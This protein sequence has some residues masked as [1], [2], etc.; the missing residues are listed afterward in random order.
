MASRD[1]KTSTYPGAEKSPRSS[2]GELSGH[3]RE[4][5]HRS[6]DKDRRDGGKRVHDRSDSSGTGLHGTRDSP[7]SSRSSGSSRTPSG[8]KHM[9][10]YFIHE[11]RELRRQI[12]PDAK[13]VRRSRAGIEEEV[14]GYQQPVGEGRSL[15][16][17]DSDGGTSQTSR[18]QMLT[19]ETK[20]VIRKAPGGD[21]VVEK[22][23][24][25]KET[26]TK[27][28]SKDPDCSPQRKRRL[29]PEIPVKGSRSS[30][31]GLPDREQAMDASPVAIKAE[32]QV[33]GSTFPGARGPLLQLEQTE[34]FTPIS[35]APVTI[36]EPM[37][38][39]SLFQPIAVAK[40]KPSKSR[41]PVKNRTID[42]GSNMK[43]QQLIDLLKM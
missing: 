17:S 26:Y 39:S 11:V 10:K 30:G 2:N 35:P 28:S 13:P 37:I 9:L 31:G 42:K 19:E 12:D 25:K 38:Q 7:N 4:K 8:K 3:R 22:T 41:I 34:V 33:L 23:F 1:P 15:F 5:K 24:S 32:V 43:E 21:L 29:L 20:E 27:H 14:S 36:E 18:Q 16:E 40:S 6:K